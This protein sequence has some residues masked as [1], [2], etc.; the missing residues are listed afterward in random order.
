[1]RVKETSQTGTIC[2]VLDALTVSILA[3]AALQ[4]A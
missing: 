4:I 3:L 1:M 2:L